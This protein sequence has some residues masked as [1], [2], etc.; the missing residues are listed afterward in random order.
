MHDPAGEMG[1]MASKTIFETSQNLALQEAAGG[2]GRGPAHE[3]V[4]ADLRHD[5]KRAEVEAIYRTALPEQIGR[6]HV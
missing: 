4:Q 2:A 6:A 1:D 3:A 5:W